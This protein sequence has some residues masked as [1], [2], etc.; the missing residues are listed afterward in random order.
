MHSFEYIRFPLHLVATCKLSSVLSTL[1]YYKYLYVLF[2]MSGGGDT[3][4]SLIAYAR[5]HGLAIDHLH[6]DIHRL[7]PPDLIT[8]IDDGTL[9]D[10]SVPLIERLLAE[11]KFRLDGKAASLLAS[12]IKPPPEPQFLNTLPDHHRIKKL[13]LEQP[14]L[15]THHLTDMKRIRRGKPPKI[16][17][18]DLT[19]IDLDEQ[20]D[21]G[22]AFPPEMLK[23]SA[24]WDKKA[25]QEKLQTTREVLKALQDILRPVYSA[26]V[27]EAI[28]KEELVFKKVSQQW[29]SC[30]S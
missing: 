11:P 4:P 7:L 20:R 16:P 19:L 2:D 25:T 3:E 28:F 24:G 27:H 6:P 1:P 12:S 22:L 13:K 30:Q 5:F 15:K 17:A 29:R 18:A 21:E 9:P 26:N 10:F 14:A 23:L 8:C